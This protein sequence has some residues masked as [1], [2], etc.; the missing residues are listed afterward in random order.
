M[1]VD[2]G[3]AL[4]GILLASAMGLALIPNNKKLAEI[5]LAAV[6]V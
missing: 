2:L 1:G 5:E 6:G 4:L 3:F